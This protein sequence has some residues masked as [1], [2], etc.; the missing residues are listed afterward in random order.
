MTMTK[1]ISALELCLIALVL[2]FLASAPLMLSP[3]QTR[4]LMHI[5]FFGGMALA[6]NILSG[7]TGYWS[8]GHTAF[9]G[10]GAFASGL[11]E[12]QLGSIFSPSVRILLGGISAVGVSLL[13]T[14]IIA[15]PILRLRGIYFAI[16]MLCFA[17]I[18]GEMSRNFSIFKGTLGISYPPLL[19]AG[20]NRLQS[21][22]Y[23]FLAVFVVTGLVF[24]LVR[25]S[26]LGVGLVC[27]GQDEDTAAMMGVPTERYKIVAFVISA[28]LTTIFGV[29]YAHSLGFITSSSVF[30]TDISLNLILYCMVGGIG[31]LYGPVIGATIM[32]LLT[33]V[34]LGEVLNL[35]MMLTGLV[36]IA[37]VAFAP[38]GLLGMLSLRPN[39]EKRAPAPALEP[40]S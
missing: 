1:K 10:I 29:I 19:F 21:A 3:F 2:S 15:T 16:G 8:F 31:T 32:I 27:V 26:R 23:A 5:L 4:V 9:V 17:E 22:F 40:Q 7:L 28:A 38:K 36:L 18:F 12:Q 20:L 6:W 30:R 13:I 11:V 24:A 35:H 14:L 39:A 25:R 33:E 34:V 37:I